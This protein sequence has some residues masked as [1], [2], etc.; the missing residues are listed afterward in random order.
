MLKLISKY[1]YIL[2]AIALFNLF[3]SVLIS[4]Y[5]ASPPKPTKPYPTPIVKINTVIK[6]VQKIKTDNNSQTTSSV[7]QSLVQAP[8]SQSC[9]VTIDGARYD[10][11]QFK[12][13]HSGGDIFKC[14]ADMSGDF[15]SRHSQKQLNQMQQYRI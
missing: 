4:N 5:V 6:K 11:I 12:R 7:T 1:I 9:V 8:V 3:A 15:W 13:I 14:G 10:I 2:S